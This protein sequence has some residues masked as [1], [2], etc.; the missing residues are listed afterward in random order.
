MAA[1]STSLV[2]QLSRFPG[3]LLD[4]PCLECHLGKLVHF[5]DVETM[6]IMAA[7]F[8]LTRVE[9]D[10]IQSA[11]P[12]KPALQKLKMFNKW[13]EIKQSEATYRCVSRS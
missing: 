2:A 4:R 6:V 13:Q 8:E 3:N 9:V 7:E 12:T 11:W 10:D 5:I 1:R